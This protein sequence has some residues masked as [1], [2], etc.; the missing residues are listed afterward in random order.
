MNHVSQKNVHFGFCNAYQNSSFITQTAH[1]NFRE[2]FYVFM[3]IYWGD[4]KAR[5]SFRIVIAIFKDS[6]HVLCGAKVSWFDL[7]WRNP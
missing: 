6:S 4:V 7:N 3:V 5:P 2:E 1:L